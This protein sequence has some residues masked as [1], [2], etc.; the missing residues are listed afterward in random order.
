MLIAI[1]NL[2]EQTSV[3]LQRFKEIKEGKHISY[4]CYLINLIAINDYRYLPNLP[5]YQLYT[6]GWHTKTYLLETLVT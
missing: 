5:N 3:F 1:K 6:S 2:P 4:Y